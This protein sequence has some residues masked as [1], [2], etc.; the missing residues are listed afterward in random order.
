VIHEGLN[1]IE[2]IS[3]LVPE[4]T[5]YAFPNI[6]RCGLSSWDFAKYLVREHKVAVVPGS[7]FGK[8]GEGYVRVSFAADFERLGEALSRIKKG[9]GAL[10]H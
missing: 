6:S 2:D 4:S 8:R 1:A 9:V 7:I 5:F 3:C 10:H